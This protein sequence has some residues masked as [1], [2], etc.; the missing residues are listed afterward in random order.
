MPIIKSAIKKMRQDA[1]R[2]LA[3]TKYRS[4]LKRVVKLAR[5]NPTAESVSKA[6]SILDKAVKKGLVHKNSAGRT[7]AAL[8][9]KA[10]ARPKGQAKEKVSS[11]RKNKVKTD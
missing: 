11:K 4:E 7:K 5:E 10:Q 2:R 3:N 9:K 6:F 1:H 8:S